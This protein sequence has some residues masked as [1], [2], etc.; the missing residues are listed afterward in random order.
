MARSSISGGLDGRPVLVWSAP[1][2]L[3]SLAIAAS[4]IS[5]IGR[6]G[7]SDHPLLRIDMREQLARPPVR[8]AHPR[9]S[10][11]HPFQSESPRSPV[12]QPSSTACS[13][14]HAL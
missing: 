3:D 7:W 12:S 11:R 13:V 9:A 8:T 2:S 6:S 10:D 14:F 1:K 4:A 5:R